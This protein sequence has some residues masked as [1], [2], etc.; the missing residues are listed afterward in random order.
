MPRNL[1]SVLAAAALLAGLAGGTASFA[2]SEDPGAQNRQGAT[3]EGNMMNMM[4]RMDEMMEKM[5]RMM[6]MCSDMLARMQ[7]EEPEPSTADDAGQ[8]P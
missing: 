7:Q 8:T 4:G 6:Q 2:Q 1:R 3:Q 5:D